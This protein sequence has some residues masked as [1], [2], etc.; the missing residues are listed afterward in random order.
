MAECKVVASGSVVRLVTQP[1][2]G[3]H[4][5]RDLLRVTQDLAKWARSGELVGL[6]MLA[7]RRGAPCLID[8]YGAPVDF[9]VEAR[10]YLLSLDDRF[11][12][13]VEQRMD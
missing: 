8:A 11:R 12:D 3:A 10:G 9:P 5:D 6:V 2:R 1:V 4:V 7:Y 13:M